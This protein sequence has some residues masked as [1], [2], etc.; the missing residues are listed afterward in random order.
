MMMCPR[1]CP[2]L[3][4]RGHPPSQPLCHA[5]S[6]HAS[7]GGS[8]HSSQEGSTAGGSG[9]STG[10]GGGSAGGGG[11]TGGGGEGGGGGGQRCFRRWQ[12]EGVRSQRM[13]VVI[14][15]LLQPLVGEKT[16]D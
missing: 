3:L 12:G 11:S 14:L 16:S 1:P 10:G 6:G 9:G 8:G 7:Q 13:N 2:R 15:F 5:C 4:H